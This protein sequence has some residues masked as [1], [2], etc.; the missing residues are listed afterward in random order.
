MVTLTLPV[1][2]GLL[3]MVV[4]VG[5]AYWRQEACQTAAQAAAM[6]SAIQAKSAVN[7]SNSITCGT[8]VAC[9]GD[10]STYVQCPSSPSSPASDNLQAGCLYAK[11]NGF[12]TGGNSSRQNVQYAAYTSGTPV[13][14][15][16]PNY[17]MRFVVA[18]KIP[19]LFSVVL[20]QP[21]MVVSARSTSGV[22]LPPGACV[23]ALYHGSALSGITLNGG[24]SVDVPCGVWDNS[25]NS[26]SLSCSNNTSINAHSRS[27]AL[28]GGNGCS[29]TVNPAPLTNQPVAN[30]PFANVPAP[31]DMNRCNSNGLTENSSVSMPADGVYEI[32]DGGITM[33]SNKTLNL[34]AGIYY[35]KN[36]TLSLQ[37]GTLS[38][39]GVT[40]FLTGN[41]TGISINGNMTVT[42][43]APTSG[44]YEGLVIYQDRNVTSPPTHT[45]NGGSSMNFAGSIY[46]PTSDVRYSGGNGSVAS[47]LIANTITFTGGTNFGTDTTG[48]VTGLQITHAYMIE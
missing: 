3:A 43:S 22:F 20:G 30:D 2:L 21:W 25:L 23:Y 34:P 27:L 42:L 16:T 31:S 19:T 39:S 9:T 8:G 7:G 11:Q 40:I 14:G 5:W 15:P 13:S 41:V 38:G 6:A 26:A 32:C 17:W 47:A 10:A 36:G 44:T 12:T 37:N 45:L 4:D 33:N 18:E 46:L 35:L 1:S 28:D 24:T 29:G 48:T